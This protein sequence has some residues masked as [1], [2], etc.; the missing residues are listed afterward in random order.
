MRRG[1]PYKRMREIDRMTRKEFAAL[2]SEEQQLWWKTPMPPMEVRA[3]MQALREREMRKS[4]LRD[5]LI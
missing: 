5:E 2:P 1:M 4:L 3:I